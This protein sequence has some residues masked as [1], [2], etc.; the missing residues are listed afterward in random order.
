MECQECQQRPAT[1]YFRQVINGKKTEI[2]V[3]E[4]CA[5]EKGYV[6]YPEEGYSLHHLL[7]GLFNVESPKVDSQQNHSMQ[8]KAELQCPQCEL[9]FSEFKRS[10]K[11]GCATCYDTF[12][13]HLNSVLR[14]VHSGNTKHNG[15]IPKREGGNLHL[16]QQIKQYQEYL[17]QLIEE[18]AFEEAA[19]VRDHIKALKE[20]QKHS[21][22]RDDA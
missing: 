15:K 20:K 9:T 11:F 22:G 7:K 5:Q 12:S 4:V 16:K 3:C 18:E 1:L 14:R 10:G 6:T 13:S 8:T 2:H 17:L 19:K 21:T